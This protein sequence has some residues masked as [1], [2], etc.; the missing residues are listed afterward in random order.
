MFKKAEKDRRETQ[1][2]NIVTVFNLFTNQ[3]AAFVSNPSFMMKA[4]Y[5]G[6][7]TFGAFHLTRMSVTMLG[8]GF[9]SRFG[10]P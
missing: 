7:L 9:M 10:K 8:A 5:Y 4:F 2:Q 6:V 3:A 1:M